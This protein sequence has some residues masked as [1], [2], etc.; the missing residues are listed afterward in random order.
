[1]I[2]NPR[3]DAV[4]VSS[5]KEGLAELD[6]G[7]SIRYV[8]AQGAVDFNQFHNS[9]GPFAAFGY[10]PGSKEI[11]VQNQVSPSLINRAR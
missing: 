3:K 7:K 10:A 1:M 8:G 11:P 9:T 6:K 4:E 5:Y 2:T